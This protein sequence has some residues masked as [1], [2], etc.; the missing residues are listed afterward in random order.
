VHWSNKKLNENY[1]NLDF[2]RIKE[3]VLDCLV[4]SIVFFLAKFLEANV[5]NLFADCSVN[6]GIDFIAIAIVYCCF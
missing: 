6:T 1:F 2:F 5:E 4:K 3:A